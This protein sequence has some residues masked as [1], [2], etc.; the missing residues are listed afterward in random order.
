VKTR[1]IIEKI[2]KEKCFPEVV[3]PTQPAI[4]ENP[5]PVAIVPVFYLFYPTCQAVWAPYE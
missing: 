1:H 5:D 2:K 4:Q 3:L